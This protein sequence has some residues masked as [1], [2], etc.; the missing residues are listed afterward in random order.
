MHAVHIVW[1]RGGNYVLAAFMN[2]ETILKHTD[3]TQQTQRERARE[4]ELFANKEQIIQM[5]C[6]FLF[7]LFCFVL[8]LFGVFFCVHTLI[9]SFALI[10]LFPLDYDTFTAVECSQKELCRIITHNLIISIV[11]CCD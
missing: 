9:V 8:F 6:D 3:L 4:W 11:I 1:C 5:I 7:V 10:L 2:I